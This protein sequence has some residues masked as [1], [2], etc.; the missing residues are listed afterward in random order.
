MCALLALGGATCADLPVLSGAK[1]PNAP[2]V[3]Q[4]CAGICDC[5]YI[6]AQCAGA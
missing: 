5:I 4:L 6:S 3:S 1:L 2:C